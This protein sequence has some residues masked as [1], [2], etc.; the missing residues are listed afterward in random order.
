MSRRRRPAPPAITLIIAAALALSPL[1]CGRRTP[2]PPRRTPIPAEIV[3]MPGVALTTR[4]ATIEALPEGGQVVL[5]EGLAR[6]DGDASIARLGVRVHAL[7]GD[8][9]EL[10]VD[11]IDAV[12]LGGLIGWLQPGASVHVAPRSQAVLTEAPASIRVEAHDLG[13]ADRPAAQSTP[14]GFTWAAPAPEGAEIGLRMTWCGAPEG[15][16]DGLARVPF[17]CQL[18]AENLGAA[19]I[20]APTITF[21]FEDEGGAVVDRLVARTPEPAPIDPGVALAYAATRAV[22]G[23][24]RWRV[25]LTPGRPR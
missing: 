17:D 9:R 22:A 6:N 20:A 4:S 13:V 16:A 2:P 19:P 5:W 24:R 10:A 12:G 21:L 7:A 15:L 3:A 14:L 23:H 11:H 8:G 25:E 18:A 1:A